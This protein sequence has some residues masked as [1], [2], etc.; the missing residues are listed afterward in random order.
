M[1]GGGVGDQSADRGAMKF[2]NPVLRIVVLRTAQA[3]LVAGLSHWLL[4]WPLTGNHALGVFLT[5]A[6]CLYFVFVFVAPWAGG[7][8][9]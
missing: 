2:E 6:L 4:G 5:P 1:A 8:R 9:F 3:S 7:C